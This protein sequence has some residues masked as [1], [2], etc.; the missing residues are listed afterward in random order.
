MAGDTT[1]TTSIVLDTSRLTPG[2]YPTRARFTSNLINID[3][4]STVE[5]EIQLVP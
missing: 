1:I 3:S 5:V 2:V 4:L